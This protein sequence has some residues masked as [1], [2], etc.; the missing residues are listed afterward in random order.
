MSSSM[1]LMCTQDTFRNRSITPFYFEDRHRPPKHSYY[2][3]AFN[4]EPTDWERNRERNKN[5][6]RPPIKS[7]PTCWL[8]LFLFAQ[9]ITHRSALLCPFSTNIF[10]SAPI[11]VLSFSH[12]F[13]ALSLQ[14]FHSVLS[15]SAFLLPTMT[16]QPQPRHK[17]TQELC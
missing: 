1:M 12:S 7:W 4:W 14:F 13:L 9:R 3:R 5:D 8:A 10:L 2:T 16:V 6:A 17:R 11:S 15:F